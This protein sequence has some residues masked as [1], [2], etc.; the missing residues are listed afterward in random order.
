ME[1]ELRLPKEPPHWAVDHH[2]NIQRTLG[3]VLA[4]QEK[5]MSQVTDLQAAEADLKTAV[6][7]GVAAID[8]LVNKLAAA[9]ASTSG[10]SA[11]VAA[12]IADM[13]STTAAMNSELTKVPADPAPATAPAPTPAA[14]PAS[15]PETG[16]APTA[17]A[18]AAA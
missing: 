13:R 9:I 3:R 6:L 16:Q 8:G 10:D 14:P 11:A 4:N 5:L 18:P 7:A 2:D 1:L 15:A 17:A 12:V